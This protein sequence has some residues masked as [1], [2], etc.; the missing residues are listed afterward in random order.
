MDENKRV[1]QYLVRFRP[2]VD[3]RNRRF[4]LVKQLRQLV[5]EA[6]A[7]DGE[8]LKLPYK[9][10]DEVRPQWCHVVNL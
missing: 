5:G 6:R 2:A 4:G 9:L 10:Q 8:T 7:F 1:Y 3:S